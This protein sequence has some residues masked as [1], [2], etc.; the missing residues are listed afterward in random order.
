MVCLSRVVGNP[1]L[2]HRVVTVESKA[3][4][5]YPAT[6]YPKCDRNEIATGG[7]YTVASI[8]PTAYTVFVD[9]PLGNGWN[10]QVYATHD[11]YVLFYGHVVCVKMPK[12][13]RLS[14]RVVTGAAPAYGQVVTG[15]S[16]TC[17]KRT[18]V[19]TGGGYAVGSINP[20]SYTVIGSRPSDGSWKV[21]AFNDGFPT[22]RVDLWSSAV[23]LQLAR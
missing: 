19:L 8:N 5:D 17:D 22:D 23:C 7:G 1:R 4:R 21:E 14:T 15:V 9:E 6:V 16:A 11:P 13:I 2:S 12:D 10:V 3:F 18:E 20:Y